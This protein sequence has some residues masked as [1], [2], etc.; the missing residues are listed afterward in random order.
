MHDRVPP[1]LL[2]SLLWNLT[3]RESQVRCLPSLFPSLPLWVEVQVLVLVYFW[4]EFMYFPTYLYFYGYIVRFY[5]AVTFT[6]LRLSL[7][8]LSRRYIYLYFMIPALPVAYL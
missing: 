3:L 7:Y 2:S 1:A 6:M 5:L 4:G 8:F